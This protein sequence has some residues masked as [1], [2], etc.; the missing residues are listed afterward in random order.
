MGL[1]LGCTSSGTN[2]VLLSYISGTIVQQK[3]SMNG[4]LSWLHSVQ[5]F[6]HGTTIERLWSHKRRWPYQWMT[7]VVLA[8]AVLARM[9][10]P[11]TGT[12]LRMAAWQFA[13]RTSF[14][15]DYLQRSGWGIANLILPAEE[16]LEQSTSCWWEVSSTN[17]TPGVGC[18]LWKYHESSCVVHWST[19]G[20]RTT[21]RTDLNGNLAPC[22]ATCGS[23][24]FYALHVG[25]PPSLPDVLFHFCIH[26]LYSPLCPISRTFLLQCYAWCT[27]LML[28]FRWE[29]KKRSTMCRTDRGYG[30]CFAGYFV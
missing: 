18:Q 11:Y 23:P 27:N 22:K 10:G 7:A 20:C 1:G 13:L 5:I 2:I 4:A 29:E 14:A 24:I 3:T 12:D 15:K 6:Q 19:H 28:R 30:H 17:N 25:H 26:T 8:L 16:W 9:C 21:C